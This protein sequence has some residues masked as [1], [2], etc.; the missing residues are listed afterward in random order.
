MQSIQIS[1]CTSVMRLLQSRVVINTA[2]R[3]RIDTFIDALVN[4]DDFGTKTEVVEDC[5]N[6]DAH[7]LR[8]YVN[9][10][11]THAQRAAH[12]LHE[13]SYRACF[14]PQLPEFFIER[15]TNP[16]DAVYDP[17]MGRGTTP[18][19][20]ALMGRQAIGND[21]SPISIL[22]TRPRLDTPTVDEIK[23]RLE[24][25]DL[26]TDC[27]TSEDQAYAVFYHA[28]TLR[29]IVALRQ[30]LAERELGGE[31]DATDEWIRLVAISR[32]T[33]HSPGF[34]SVYTLPPNQAAPIE[35]QRRINQRRNQT[36]PPRDVKNLI[37]RKSRSLLRHGGLNYPNHVLSCCDATNTQHIESDSIDLVVTSPPFL[38]VVNYRNDNHVRAWFSGIDV[39]NHP[40]DTP[41]STEQWKRFTADT[42]RELCRVVK[43]GGIICYEVGEVRNA[44]INLE[45]LV[46]AA[47]LEAELPVEIIGVLVNQQEFSKTSNIWGI[48]NSRRGTN[49]NRVVMLAVLG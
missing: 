25:V 27:V 13:I 31:L 18:I 49:T 5:S 46:C 23:K 14:K 19:Q 20:A 9:E 44:T 45:D 21:A 30:Y 10:F 11:W 17:F 33:G 22:M 41:S 32:L 48:T 1:A 36:P 35:S 38:D 43:P 4:F 42:L 47:A 34:F 26:V 28:S 16:G 8:Y 2:Q 29:Q 12:S 39:D 24:S 37:L 15:L 6:N 7:S 3:N 40:I